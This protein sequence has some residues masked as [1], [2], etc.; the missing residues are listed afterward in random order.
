[1]NE[2]QV[3][4]LK[5]LHN[6]LIQANMMMP[7]KDVKELELEDPDL[8]GWVSDLCLSCKEAIELIG[9]DVLDVHRGTSCI[10]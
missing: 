8:A 9:G 7:V 4:L 3:V 2:Y 6:P 5:I 10:N 1:M